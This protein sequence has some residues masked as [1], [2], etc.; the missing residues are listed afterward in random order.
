MKIESIIGLFQKGLA[1]AI[2]ILKQVLAQKGTKKGQENRPFRSLWF[3][4]NN[5]GMWD[6]R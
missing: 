5:E 4:V 1:N 2:L 3:C 6:S